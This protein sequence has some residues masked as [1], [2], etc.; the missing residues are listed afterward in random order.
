MK[1]E[2]IVVNPTGPPSTLSY[3]MGI[4]SEAQMAALH[5]LI[6]AKFGGTMRLP[7]DP[8]RFWLRVDGFSR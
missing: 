2:L 6:Q 3:L 4:E 5:T 7:V 8:D 1:H